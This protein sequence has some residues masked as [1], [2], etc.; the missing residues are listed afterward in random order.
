MTQQTDSYDKTLQMFRDLPGA[1]NM[2]RLRFLRWLVERECLGY[3]P[4][5]P[6]SGEFAEPPTPRPP[7]PGTD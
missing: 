3:R 1:V 2:A 5:G 4:A 7:L 6:P